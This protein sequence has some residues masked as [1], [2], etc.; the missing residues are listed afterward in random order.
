VSAAV[1][2]VLVGAELVEGRALD[3]N[4]AW[5]AR[6]I[7]ESGARVLRWAAV[8]DDEEAI[9]GA[10]RESAAVAPLVLVSGGLG[11]TDDDRTRSGLARAAGVPLVEDAA[12]W[13][14]IEGVFR[15][16]G[17]VPKAVQRRQAQVPKGARWLANP[18]GTAPALEVRVGGATVL[19]FPGVPVELRALFEAEALPRIRALPGLVP[20]ALR[21]LATAGLP[22]TDVAERLG[23][24]RSDP[25]LVVGWYPHQGEVE[26]S[27]RAHGPGCEEVAERA[28]RVALE[29]LGDA[30]LDAGPGERIEHAVVRL[31]RARG[32]RLTSAESVTGGLVARMLTA[33][34][35]ASEVFPGGYVTYSNQAKVRELGVPVLLLR[36]QGPVSEP[37]VR[38][39]AEGALRRAE[40]DAALATTGVAGPGDLATA[41]AAPVPAGTAYVAVALRDRPTEALRLSLPLPRELFQRRVAV[42]AL[43]RLRRAVLGEVWGR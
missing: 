29:R 22:E 2:L 1:G 8:S 17:R 23:D 31:L 7:T 5:M 15:A 20:T 37:V 27:L 30:V 25:G 32:L 43:D 19:A 12:A 35:G 41:G 16:R 26:V 21:L 9:A 24:L 18:V 34:P 36:E 13:A 3:E 6:R 33:V 39:M 14:W 10:V 28:R 40:V 42:E 11:P 4:G 38:A